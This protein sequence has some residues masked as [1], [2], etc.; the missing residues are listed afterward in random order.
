MTSFQQQLV[1]I[2]NAEQKRWQE[3]GLLECIRDSGTQKPRSDVPQTGA[4]EVSKYWRDGVGDFERNGCTNVAW[5]AAFVCWCLRQAGLALA[6]FPFSSGHHAYIRW[7]IRNTINDKQNKSYYGRRLTDYAPQPGDMIAQWRKAKP[8]DPDPDI[9][10]DVQPDTF[11]SSH[12]DIVVAAFPD[13][14]LAVGGNVSD[15]VSVS[16]FP[17]ASGILE[18]G[19]RLICVMQCSV[20][21]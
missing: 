11:Y 7:A 4:D 9:T 3:S 2:V 10:F 13:R 6:D 12:C 17:A 15:R 18:P 14:I 16:T 21:G 19:K 5:S 8:T 1:A 20:P